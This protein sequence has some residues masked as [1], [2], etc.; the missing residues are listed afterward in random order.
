[1]ACLHVV[2]AEWLVFTS[3]GLQFMKKCDVVVMLCICIQELRSSILSKVSGHA[4]L[5][6]SWFFSV[7]HD[8]W[9]EW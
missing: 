4:N 8:E 2:Y 9:L 7:S 5:E 6:L 1:M 3:V